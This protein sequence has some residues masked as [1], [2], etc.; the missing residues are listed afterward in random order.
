ML[1]DH[2]NRHPIEIGD[3][4][5]CT[6]LG[7]PEYKKAGLVLERIYYVEH[8][9]EETT[10]HPDEYSCRVLFDEGERMVRAKWLK[11]LSRNKS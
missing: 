8:S 3:L 5:K 6:L 11:A 4:V 1:E 2:R 7:S 9:G 10:Q